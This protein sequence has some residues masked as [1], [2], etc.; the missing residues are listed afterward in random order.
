[1][2]RKAAGKNKQRSY[3]QRWG[4][5]WCVFVGML[6]VMAEATRL[7][8]T[9]NFH[10]LLMHYLD[11]DGK[12]IESEYTIYGILF[13]FVGTWTGAVF[14]MAGI[15]WE[16]RMLPKIAKTFRQARGLAGRHPELAGVP[17]DR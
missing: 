3:W 10:I 5:F 17:Q 15:L 1:M 4:P 7:I 14:L 9:D 12:P 6:G 11:K 8:L 13:T 16:T 2:G